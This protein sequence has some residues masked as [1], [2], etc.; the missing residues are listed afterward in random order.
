MRR[1]RARQTLPQGFKHV[2]LTEGP[3]SWILSS[4]IL[5]MC[6]MSPCFTLQRRLIRDTCL[7][8]AMSCLTHGLDGWNSTLVVKCSNCGQ[9]T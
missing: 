2:P 8:V 6:Y 9:H 3:L 4:N 5:R 1:M 7:V